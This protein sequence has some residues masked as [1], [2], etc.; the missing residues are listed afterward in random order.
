MSETRDYC[1]HRVEIFT[2][3]TLSCKQR[4]KSLKLF[5]KSIFFGKIEA[6]FIRFLVTYVPYYAGTYLPTYLRITKLFTR[7][8]EFQPLQLGTVDAKFQV[9]IFS[10]RIVL[11]LLA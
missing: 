7:L 3:L 6:R 11:V 2:L 10:A 8:T 5:G 9:P 4:G 1:E